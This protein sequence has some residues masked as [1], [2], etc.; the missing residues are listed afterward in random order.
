MEVYE[1]LY[2]PLYEQLPL[3]LIILLQHVPETYR[4]S[5]KTCASFERLLRRSHKSNFPVLPI[6]E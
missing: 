4:V 6:Y 2:E 3:L 5:Q 1:Q